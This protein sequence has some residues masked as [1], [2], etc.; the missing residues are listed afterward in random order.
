MSEQVYSDISAWLGELIYI[1]GPRKS[2]PGKMV[3]T[4]PGEVIE[5]KSVFG[6][7]TQEWENE[8][9]PWGRNVFVI[10]QKINAA[11]VSLKCWSEGR[12]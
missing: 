9:S 8:L 6:K 2:S 7:R 5:Q 10:F 1:L 4:F 3:F 11:L 12:K